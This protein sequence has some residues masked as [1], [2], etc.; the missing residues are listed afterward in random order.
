VK[1]RLTLNKNQNMGP[2]ENV[3]AEWLALLLRILEVPDLKPEPVTGYPVRGFRV[4]IG[5]S[6]QMPGQFLKLGHDLQFYVTASGCVFDVHSLFIITSRHS[7]TTVTD[8]GWL[9]RSTT[10]FGRSSSGSFH[11]M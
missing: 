8:S 3:V 9:S 10:G 5:P 7:H 1:I 11:K 6:R 2:F 4:F